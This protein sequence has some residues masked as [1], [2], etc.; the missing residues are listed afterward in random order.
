MKNKS[1]TVNHPVEL[2]KGLSYSG[3]ECSTKWSYFWHAHWNF[4]SRQIYW[5]A[6]HPFFTRVLIRNFLL[7]MI[8]RRFSLATLCLSFSFYLSLFFFMPGKNKPTLWR[9]SIPRY[10]LKM[11]HT[12]PCI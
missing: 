9:H 8:H 12:P 6:R 10:T 11:H 2:F 1:E 7:P 3:D 4:F 5:E